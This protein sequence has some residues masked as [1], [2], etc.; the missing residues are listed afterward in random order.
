[1]A[2]RIVNGKMTKVASAYG[3]VENCDDC[4]ACCRHMGGPG[5]NAFAPFYPA[6]GEISDSMKTLPDYERW[7]SL[8]SQ[9]REP[10][11]EYHEGIRSGTVEDRTK[12][13]VSYEELDRAIALGAVGMQELAIKRSKATPL[14]CLWY[15]EASKRCKHY[16]HRPDVCRDPEVMS[17]GNPACLASR[18][19]FRIP[20]PMVTKSAKGLAP[21]AAS[22]RRS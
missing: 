10:L 4:G 6:S 2:F 19:H 1:M 20:L 18:K 7:L 8:P 17:P 15:D 3:P 16:E 12:A 21:S 5:A 9:L 14:P 13:F 11:R 22:E